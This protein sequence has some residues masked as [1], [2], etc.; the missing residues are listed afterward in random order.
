MTDNTELLALSDEK[1]LA[2]CEIHIY[3]ASGPGGQHRNKV[4][5]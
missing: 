2:Q 1:L 5:S 3:R 4:S